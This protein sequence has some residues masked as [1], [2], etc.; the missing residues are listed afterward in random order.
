VSVIVPSRALASL[1]GQPPIT[2]LAGSGEGGAPVLSADGALLATVAEGLGRGLPLGDDLCRVLKNRLTVTH[3]GAEWVRVCDRRSA[4]EAERLLYSTLGSP[5]DSPLDIAF[6]RRAS[7]LVTRSAIARGLTPNAITMSSLVVG[8]G[9]A[10]CFWAAT[11][12]RAVAGLLLYAGSVVLDHAD[13]EVA[14]LQYR[15]SRFGEWLD[16]VCDT[17]VHTMVVVG[18][19]VTAAQGGR[20]AATAIGAIAAGGVVVVAAGTHAYWVGRVVYLIARRG[21]RRG[22]PP[23]DTLLQREA[24]PPNTARMPK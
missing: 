24:R 5:I 18:M 15:E 8:L 21:T 23:S 14:R 16:I 10:W 3:S 17:V 7:R 11:P 19:S 22:A 2:V 13:G 9:A 20:A 12:G 6:H 1:L 4:A